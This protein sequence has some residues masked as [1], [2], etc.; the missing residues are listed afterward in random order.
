MARVRGGSSVAS[1]RR[2]MGL[3]ILFFFLTLT[4]LLLMIGQFVI[5]EKI[6]KAGGYFGIF[7]AFIAYYCGAANLFTEDST[8]FRLPLA[9][10]PGPKRD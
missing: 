8:F 4:F 9:P 10:I 6:V 1:L 2:N 5:N 3:I 7:T